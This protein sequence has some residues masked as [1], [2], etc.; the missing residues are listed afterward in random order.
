MAEKV[1]V[2]KEPYRIYYANLVD[3]EGLRPKGL[4]TGLIS[5]AIGYQLGILRRLVGSGRMGAM[6]AGSKFYYTKPKY[7]ERGHAEMLS[8]LPGFHS[9]K[10]M[11]ADVAAVRKEMPG[12]WRIADAIRRR[13]KEMIDSK[14]FTPQIRKEIRGSLESQGLTRRNIDRVFW[15]AVDEH[16]L[17]ISSFNKIVRIAHRVARTHRRARI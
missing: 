16:M 2:A 6:S 11:E 1:E 13:N 7:V 5:T 3:P 9:V 17:Y 4:K 10:K 8:K 15:A 14:G 12:A